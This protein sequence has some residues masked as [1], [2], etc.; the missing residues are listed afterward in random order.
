MLVLQRRPDDAIVFPKLGITV[1]I[2]R[3][4][5]Q[6]ARVGIEAP[7]DVR[8]LR[9]ELTDG[10]SQDTLD[11]ESFGNRLGATRRE[12]HELRNRLNTL[13]LGL[14]LY[15][16]QTDAGLLEEANVT[17]LRVIEQL[18]KIE[19]TVGEQVRQ[20]DQAAENLV[21]RP[22]ADKVRLLLVEDDQDQR[23]MLAGVLRMRGCRV[24]AV[25]NGREA[26]DYIRGNRQPDYILLDM[27]M[28]ELDGPSVI[29]ELQS[30]ES[31]R[32]IPIVALSG[33]DPT[34][35]LEEKFVENIDCWFPKPINTDGLI[36]YVRTGMSVAD[37][38]TIE[39]SETT[40]E[41]KTIDVTPA[42]EAPQAI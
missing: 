23:E 20:A 42:I 32:S 7:P 21:A 18:E 12:L 16:Y 31:S 25:S 8:V 24:D 41:T 29:R 38:V 37:D 5:R 14:Q 2:L 39:H 6:V 15:R 9:Q 30:E 35:F 1:R 40:E 19:Q 34:E 28:P 11:V 13:N 36:D 27:R 22:S 10:T 26:I 33:A 17:F 4:S 3:L